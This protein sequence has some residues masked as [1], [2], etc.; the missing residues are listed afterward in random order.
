MNTTQKIDQ[1]LAEDDSSEQQS[2]STLV[3]PA[4][5]NLDNAAYIFGLF[6]SSDDPSGA[7]TTVRYSECSLFQFLTQTLIRTFG[8]A[9]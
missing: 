8:T 4:V 5:S 9:G 2:G 3:A 6:H 7:P 1:F